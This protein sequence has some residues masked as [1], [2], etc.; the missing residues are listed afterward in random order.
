MQ[1]KKSLGLDILGWWRDWGN[2][3]GKNEKEDKNTPWGKENFLV[4]VK[5]DSYMQKNLLSYTMYKNRLKMDSRLQSKTWNY[6]NPRRKYR[7]YTF[8]HWSQEYFLDVSS[9]KGNKSKNKQMGTNQIKKLW[10]SKGNYQQNKKAKYWMEQIFAND[11]SNKGLIHKKLIH[12]NIKKKKKRKK[13]MGKG[14]E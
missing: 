7:P 1:V 10:H 11:V 2:V 14:T 3:S 13:K 8:W 12:L 6:K 5:L 4:L 9:G